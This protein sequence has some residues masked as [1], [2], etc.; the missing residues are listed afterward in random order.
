M[1]HWLCFHQDNFD[2]IKYKILSA[3]GGRFDVYTSECKLKVSFAQCVLS[4][5]AE[6]PCRKSYIFGYI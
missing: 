5:R 3:I 6:D 2:S 4:Q 1:L